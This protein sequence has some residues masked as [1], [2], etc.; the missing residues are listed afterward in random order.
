LFARLQVAVASTMASRGGGRVEG[1]GQLSLGKA[2]TDVVDRGG[3]PFV[4]GGDV[5]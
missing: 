3:S 1:G 5:E 4:V 2:L